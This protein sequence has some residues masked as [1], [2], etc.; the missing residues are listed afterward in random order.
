MTSVLSWTISVSWCS[1]RHVKPYLTAEETIFCSLLAR[2][3]PVCCYTCSSGSGFSSSP[4]IFLALLGLR[5]IRL[6]LMA[7]NALVNSLARDLRFRFSSG[8]VRLFVCPSSLGCLMLPW[9]WPS[10]CGRVRLLVCS[11]AVC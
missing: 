10:F 3:L 5:F 2:S 11:S 1:I 8:V 7:T 4:S 6:L 9:F